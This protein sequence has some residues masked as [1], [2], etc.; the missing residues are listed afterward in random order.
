MPACQGTHCHEKRWQLLQVLPQF[1]WATTLLAIVSLVLVIF[2]SRIPRMSRVPGPLCALVVVTAV[3][4][5]F[6]F[7]SVATIGSTFF[8]IPRGLPTFHWPDTPLNQLL[9]PHGP[10]FPHPI[11]GR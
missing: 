5:L 11:P 6:N 10:P 8:E 3:Q 1:D 9:E 2:T 4:A 7:E